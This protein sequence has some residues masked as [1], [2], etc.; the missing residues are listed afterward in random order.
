MPQLNSAA[1]YHICKYGKISSEWI[2]I[3]KDIQL[4]IKIPAGMRGRIT[5]ENGWLFENGNTFFNAADGTYILHK[6]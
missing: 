1:G 6:K 4:T 3:G 2:R 5:L